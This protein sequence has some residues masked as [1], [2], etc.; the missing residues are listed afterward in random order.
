[1]K[2]LTIL[3]GTLMLTLSSVAMAQEDDM[4]FTSR[5]EKKET[6]P[7][8]EKT[9]HK[10]EIVY[11]TEEPVHAPVSGVV[12]TSELRD[13]DEYNRRGRRYSSTSADT[14]YADAQEAD[15]RQTQTYE[16]SAQSLYD[17]GYSEGY[18]QGYSDGD[19]MDFYYGLRLARFHGRHFYD[20]W[21]W[22]SISYVY[23]PWHWDP[24]YYDPWYRPY[25]YGGWYSVGWGVGYWGSYWNPYWP[26]YYPHHH[27]HPHWG[28][29]GYYGHGPRISTERNRDYGRTR[30]VDRSNRVGTS[31]RYEGS[32]GRRNT[33]SSR[34][35]G[36]VNDRSSRFSDRAT[37]RYNRVT[38]RSSSRSGSRTIDRSSERR[39]ERTVNRSTDRTTNRNVDRSSNRSTSRSVD[40]SS[41]RSTERSTS[42]SVDRSSNRS[43]GSYS[44]SSRGGG[45]GSHSGGGFGSHGGGSRGGG[46]GR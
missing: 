22:G 21:Y 41:S 28:H 33:V 2:H 7:K 19:D 39:T 31:G 1:M 32:T 5:K 6:A 10:V 14:L 35:P 23:D 27:H 34:A 4:Y 40:R 25:Y 43:G 12:A 30:I 29:A 42:R 13:V 9:T 38:D 37:D 16:L 44:S 24:W 45:F 17:L 46:R 8:A 15:T 20:P 11:E 36:R 26:G 18:S 3:L